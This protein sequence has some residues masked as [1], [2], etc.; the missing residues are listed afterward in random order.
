MR[1]KVPATAQST[2]QA[3]IILI[4]FCKRSFAPVGRDMLR[5]IVLS[6]VQLEFSNSSAI[7]AL[8]S[9]FILGL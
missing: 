7:I 3:E 4:F 2:S 1:K 5:G 9:V 8:N 6:L